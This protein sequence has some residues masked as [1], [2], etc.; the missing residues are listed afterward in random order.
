[1]TFSYHTYFIFLFLLPAV[2]LVVTSPVVFKAIKMLI[3]II[4]ERDFNGN[5]QK[6]ILAILV[7]GFCVIPQMIYM[8][9][10]G[11]FLLFERADDAVTATGVVESI[12]EPSSYFP[13]LRASDHQGADVVI[14][15]ERYFMMTAEAL[16]IGDEVRIS[17]LPKSGVVMEYKEM[18]E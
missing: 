5:G 8:V 18:G 3:G 16:E 17:Y 4:L 14:D 10:G 13:G 6:I 11:F 7:V 12:R 9:S 15:G 2:V 1:M